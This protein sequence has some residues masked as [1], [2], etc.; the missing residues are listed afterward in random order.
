MIDWSSVVC[1]SDLSPSRSCFYA[2]VGPKAASVRRPGLV[3]AGGGRAAPPLKGMSRRP[4]GLNGAGEVRLVVFLP[5]MPVG[6]AFRRN[7]VG[8]VVQPAMTQIGRA[9]CGERG[10]QY[11]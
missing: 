7:G 8:G 1:S 9:S 4:I 11:V 3:V 10:G 6:T 5:G 2:S